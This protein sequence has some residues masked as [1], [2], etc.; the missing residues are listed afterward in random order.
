[1]KIDHRISQNAANNIAI[2]HSNSEG[3]KRMFRFIDGLSHIIKKLFFY[4]LDTKH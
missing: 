2:N 1:M 3:A 4:S